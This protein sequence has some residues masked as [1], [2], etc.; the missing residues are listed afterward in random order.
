MNKEPQ[1]KICVGVAYVEIGIA[2]VAGNNMQLR[3]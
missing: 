2:C 3:N 1:I